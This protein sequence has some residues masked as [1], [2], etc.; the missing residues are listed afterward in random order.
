MKKN[1]NNE[2]IKF[3]RIA[4]KYCGFDQIFFTQAS[5]KIRCFKCGELLRI[6][7]KDIIKKI[8]EGMEEL[9]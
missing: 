8:D 6:P 9:E 4:C 5:I 2:N 3:V 7:T 1:F